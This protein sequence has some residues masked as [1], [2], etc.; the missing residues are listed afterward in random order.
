MLIE[1]ASAYLDLLMRTLTRYDLGDE[2]VVVSG[3]RPLT[4]VVAR[5]ASKVLRRRGLELTKVVPFDPGR[6]AEGRDAPSTAETMVGLR[7][8]E[9]LQACIATVVTDRVEGDVLEAGVW[10]GGA[11]I[12]ARAAL[13][14]LGG[15]A[16]TVWVADSF[17]GLPPPAS[18]VAADQGD[19]HW[20]STYLAVGLEQVKANF[21]KY[22]LLD[23]RVRFLK[24]WFADT[25]PGAPI[26]KL[27]VLRADGDMYQS[28]MDILGPLYDKVEPGGFVIIDDYG[29]LPGCQQAVDDFRR[30]RGINDP[31]TT[32]D[33]TGA[34]WRK[35]T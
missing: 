5:A 22:G 29:A 31:M 24:G 16:R 18:C 8:L 19:M 6:R 26:D 32:I 35:V 33:W 11:S 23:D 3:G 28:T 4:K 17:E 25:L 15:S 10:R 34:Y 27:A 20:R 13:D 30:Q 14:V 9:N 7:R 2:H 21:A 1:P 12:F